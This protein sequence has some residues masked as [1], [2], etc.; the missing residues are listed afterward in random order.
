[1]ALYSQIQPLWHRIFCY[2][3]TPELVTLFT[4]SKISIRDPG[5]IPGP[6]K[7]LHGGQVLPDHGPGIEP[8]SGKCYQIMDRE[9][10]PDAMTEWLNLTIAGGQVQALLALQ[11]S[12]GNS[13]LDLWFCRC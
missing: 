10:N 2:M 4:L 11:C 7:L 13:T 6:F 1:M 9:S 3:T 12:V 8:G 5:S